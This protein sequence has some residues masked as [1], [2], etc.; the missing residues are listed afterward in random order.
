M[1]SY[2]AKIS[3]LAETAALLATLN[4]DYAERDRIL[5]DFYPSEL[6]KFV[7]QLEGLAE[8]GEEILGEKSA[9]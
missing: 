2:D 7:Q 8:R 9:R 5:E 1:T 4:E 6:R 3:S